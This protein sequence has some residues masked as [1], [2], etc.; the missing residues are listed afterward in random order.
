MSY[1]R[2]DKSQRSL[3]QIQP[4]ANAGFT[5]GSEKLLAM[6][7]CDEEI[8]IPMRFNVCD[9]QPSKHPEKSSICILHK[10]VVSTFPHVL[11]DYKFMLEKTF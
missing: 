8:V 9:Q 7:S 4:T 6:T 3:E 10:P 2:R 5:I 1:D 11:L